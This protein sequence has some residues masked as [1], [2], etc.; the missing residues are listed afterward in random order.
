MQ[1]DFIDVALSSGQTPVEAARDLMRRP[2]AERQAILD[3]LRHNSELTQRQKIHRR[4]YKYLMIQSHI[5][6]IDVEPQKDTT[7]TAADSR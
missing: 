5:G 4:V 2:Y 3:A 7:S 6:E 1:P